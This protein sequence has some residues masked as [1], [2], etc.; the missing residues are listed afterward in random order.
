MKLFKGGEN[1]LLI[2]ELCKASSLLSRMQGLLG[3]SSLSAN[4]GLWIL[5]CNSIHT[6]FMKYPI[7]C[8]F[9]DKSMKVT[10][11]KSDVE[12]FRMVWPQRKADSVIELA[13]GTVQKLQIK[14]GD[15]LHVGH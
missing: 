2:E 15:Q 8:V 9:V 4:A 1:L 3:S 13:A 7:D 14:I 5:R 12:P 11:I 6:F 10:S